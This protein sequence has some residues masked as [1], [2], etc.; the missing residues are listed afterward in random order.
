MQLSN[1]PKSP[2]AAFFKQQGF[3]LLD[4]GLATELEKRGHNLNNNLWSA[5]LLINH[6]Q[7]IRKVHLSYLDAG[8]DCITTATYQASIPG[9]AEQ[10]ISEKKAKSLLKKA[11]EIASEAREQYL[12]NSKNKNPSRIRP[13]IAVSIGPFGAYLADGSEFRGDYSVSTQ[14][15][16]SFHESRWEILA[17]SSADI[18]AFE[19]IPSFREAVVLLELLKSTPE[20]YAWISFSCTDGMRISDGTH[21]AECAELFVNCEQ[22]VGV[23]VNCTAPQYISSLIKQVRQ[24]APAKPIVIYPNSGEVY[25]ENRKSWVGSSDLINLG[26]AAIEWFNLGARLLGGCCR[27]TPSQIADMRRALLSLQIRKTP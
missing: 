17:D 8:A 24:G 12:D 19:T 21:L 26:T 10:G 9:F 15:L 16:R 7:E 1:S 3:V 11:V 13:L 23:G 27:T 5:S 25:D 22:I 6:P 14:E 4:G 18:F 20:V 2:I